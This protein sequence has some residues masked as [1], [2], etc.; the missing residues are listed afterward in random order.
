MTTEGHALAT[1]KAA[2]LTADR[3]IKVTDLPVPT[4]NSDEYLVRIAATGICSSDV[5]RTFGGGAYFYPLIPGHEM[6]GEIVACG[7]AVD[8]RL[9]IGDRVTVF[10]LLPCFNCP[11]CRE[12]H[13]ARCQSY[14]YYGSRRH[15]G[16]AEYLAVKAWNLLPIPPGVAM[17]DAALCEPAAVTVHA[18][19]RLVLEGAG[20]DGK[21]LVLGAGF[22]GLMA[23]QLIRRFHPTTRVVL[24][25][26][27]AYKLTIGAQFGAEAVHL[28]DAGSWAAFV[29]S[30][31]GSFS[32]VLEAVGVPESFRDA[33]ALADAGGR[34]VWMGNISGDLQLP[35][36]L[37]SSVLRKEIEIVG[38][39]NSSYRG[40]Q[41]SDWTKALEAMAQGWRPS[42]LVNCSLTLAELP[43]TLA[44]LADHKS[45]RREFSILKALVWP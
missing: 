43:D 28:P 20:A 35:K 26:R 41:P 13:Y 45:R 7:A 23:V 25:D 32:R 38:T 21:V 1:M 44:A 11:S 8:D 2:V 10:P 16:F 15:G 34:V 33:L 14:G 19:D 3:Q 39:W 36:A 40:E 22:L 42:A 24:A 5:T 27:N 37:V 31:V 12:Q 30:H 4:P 17:E 18:L 6:A 29:G 9:A